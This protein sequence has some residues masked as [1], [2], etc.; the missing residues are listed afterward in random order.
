LYKF[1]LASLAVRVFI[2]ILLNRKQY[3][4]PKR[5][6]Q[7]DYFTANAQLNGEVMLATLLRVFAGKVTILLNPFELIVMWLGSNY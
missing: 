7:Q 3:R 5:T 1:A 2:Y 6:F 4:T